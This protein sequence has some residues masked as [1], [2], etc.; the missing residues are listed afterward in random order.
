[1]P[2]KTGASMTGGNLQK[3]SQSNLMKVLSCLDK[4]IDT[5]AAQKGLFPAQVKVLQPIN[6]CAV[7]ND[8]EVFIVATNVNAGGM[9]IHQYIDW[10]GKPMDIK[11]AVLIVQRDMAFQNPFGFSFKRDILSFD[12]DEMDTACQQIATQ[13][14][15]DEIKT[16]ERLKN[17]VRIQ[18]I[19]QG[20]DF[21]INENLIFVLSPFKDPFDTI[22]N[23]HIKSTVEGIR[24]LSCIRADDIYD[25]KPI[26]ED[27]WKKINEAKI[28]ISELTDRN[29]N[30]FYETGVAHTVGKE[31]ILIT[32]S[33]NDVPFDLKHLRCIVYDYTPRGIQF[34]ES[35]LKN[36]IDQIMHRA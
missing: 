9:P 16:N 2:F 35:N 5:V 20:R 11:S 12:D 33:M 34:L 36:T 28:I 13:Y 4:H 27:I 8:G 1:M 3:K 22:F 21:L 18:P 30:V 7:V 25:N 32:Q 6:F 15:E 10:T 23:D 29:P 31:V 19:F 17:I 14:I 24:N 26:I